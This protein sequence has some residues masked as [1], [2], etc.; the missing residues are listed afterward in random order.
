MARDRNVD[1]YTRNNLLLARNGS[2]IVATESLDGRSLLFRVAPSSWTANHVK[3]ERS[4]GIG[5]SS[6]AKQ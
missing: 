4:K 3:H 5:V 1:G 6:Y 2:A